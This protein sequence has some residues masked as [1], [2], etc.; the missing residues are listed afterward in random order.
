[1]KKIKRYNIDT[2]FNGE[3]TEQIPRLEEDGRWCESSDVEKIEEQLEEKWISVKERLPPYILD[4]SETLGYICCEEGTNFVYIAQHMREDDDDG[5]AKY[6]WWCEAL[7]SI[8]EPT[9]WMPLPIS[10]GL[11]KEDGE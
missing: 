7:E 2:V 8:E 5:N 4:T 3:F 6:F 9:H 11:E 10:K 1:M